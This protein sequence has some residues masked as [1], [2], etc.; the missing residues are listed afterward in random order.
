MRAPAK[1]R[2][3]PRR[4]EGN[5]RAELLAV[6]AR[7]F[8]EKGFDGTTIRDISA[9]A[10]MHSGSPFYH[11]RTKQEMLV[12]VMEE[13][14]AEGLK[15]SQA[16]FAL[17]LPPAERFRRLVRIHLGT[18]LEDGNDFIPV[19]LYEIRSLTPANRRRIIA[20]KDG[21]DA[22]WQKMIDELE[23][24]GLLAGDRR[25]AR[26]FV[27]GALNWTAQWYRPAGR[28]SIDGIAEETAAVFLNSVA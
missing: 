27:L 3:A 7:L 8:R 22:L 18:I 21:Y 9:A 1:K 20:L 6:C 24:A 28:L 19:L 5:R 12:A 26:L 23:E 10:G 14:L 2:A 17:K 13:G 11:F 4:S 16:V 25:L 15:R